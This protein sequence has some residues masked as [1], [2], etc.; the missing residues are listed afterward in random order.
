[1]DTED[2]KVVSLDLRD[3]VLFGDL[4]CVLLQSLRQV[5]V[6]LTFIALM[7]FTI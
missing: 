1:M 7:M 4:D 5:C 6:T 2:W 3:N